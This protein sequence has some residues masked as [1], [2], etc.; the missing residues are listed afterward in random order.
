M[1][2][3]YDLSEAPVHLSAESARAWLDGWNAAIETLE[4]DRKMTRTV[5][6]WTKLV[7]ASVR[8]KE[9]QDAEAIARLCAEAESEGRAASTWHMTSVFYG[10]PCCCAKCRPDIKRL[11]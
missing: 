5:E 11:A 8:V 10:S 6:D 3:K 1:K 2:P 7:R 4:G 9:P